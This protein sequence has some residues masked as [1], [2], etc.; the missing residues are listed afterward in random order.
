MWKQINLFIRESG[1]IL[2]FVLFLWM[3]AWILHRY[4]IP[5]SIERNQY[6]DGLITQLDEIFS[7]KIGRERQLKAL[8]FSEI[9][10]Q[11][12]RTHLN[13]MLD[14]ISIAFVVSGILILAVD[15][16]L[17][18]QTKKEIRQYRDEI[19]S[20][21]WKA[22]S[23]RLLPDEI[24]IEIDGILKQDVIKSDSR[25]TI[26]FKAPYKGMD[27]GLIIL[28]REMSYKLQNLTYQNRFPYTIETEIIPSVPEILLTNDDGSKLTIPCHRGFMVNN[29]NIDLKSVLDPDNQKKL[30]HLVYLAEDP[31]AY[32]EIY[33][34]TEEAKR[35]CDV[36]T[37][38]TLSSMKNLRIVVRNE[39]P[40]LIKVK[41]ILLRHPKYKDFTRSP[42]DVW[43]F[44]G[45][46]LPGQGFS[47]FWDNV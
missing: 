34:A 20:D 40:H 31:Q 47:V 39:I 22:V 36:Y 46:L 35:V 44:R 28:R 41:Q 8:L 21:V 24:G 17:R 33:S 37:S 9:M 27:D 45:G 2:I 7:K 26:T 38:T 10:S 12:R 1:R 30:R 18:R 13:R 15:I 23:K 3:V 19:G 11:E 4:A 16:H 43:E 14:H 32:F 29:D 5:D 6:A 25:F 42:D